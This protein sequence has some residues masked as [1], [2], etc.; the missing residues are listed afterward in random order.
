[1][2]DRSLIDRL[3]IVA[4]PDWVV[5]ISLVD[6][7]FDCQSAQFVCQRPIYVQLD[8]I[9]AAGLRTVGIMAH[10]KMDI[11]FEQIELI[12][13]FYVSGIDHVM[14]SL[15]G[16]CIAKLCYGIKGMCIGQ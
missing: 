7:S 9:L 3:R 2:K 16:I 4:K 5:A 11:L 15:S 12:V 8:G 1:V 10:A 13:L 14:W 6:R